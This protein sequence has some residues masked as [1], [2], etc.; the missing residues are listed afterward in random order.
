MNLFAVLLL[1]S[2]QCIGCIRSFNGFYIC[3]KLNLRVSWKW[4]K[5]CLCI[6]AVL[7]TAGIVVAPDWVTDIAILRNILVLFWH[8]TRKMATHD[9]VLDCACWGSSLYFF[10]ALLARW[11][12]WPY[13]GHLEQ[14]YCTIFAHL[15]LLIFDSCCVITEVTYR[16]ENELNMSCTLTFMCAMCSDDG[17]WLLR[18]GMNFM[19]YLVGY[20][21]SV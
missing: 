2:M 14:G 1:F 17:L 6:S 11:Q 5:P 3:C 16:M 10:D 18:F 12:Q 8:V 9:V 20:L 15:L 4:T 21:I 19:C 7:R 13:W